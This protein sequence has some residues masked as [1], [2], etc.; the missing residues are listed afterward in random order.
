[1]Q[2]HF[3]VWIESPYLNDWGE[4]AKTDA[5][6][7]GDAELDSRTEPKHSVINP[8]G[9]HYGLP[10]EKPHSIRPEMPGS[11]YDP[12]MTRELQTVA[13][14]AGVGYEAVSSDGSRT[15]FAGSRGLLI[16]ERGYTR[17]N[18]AIFEE[19]LHT[20]VYE[21]FIEHEVSFGKPPLRMPG[22]DEDKQRY[23]RARYNR[24][25]QEWVDPLK[26]SKA[27]ESKI[28]SRLTTEMDEAEDM[29][30]DI[31]E[32]YQTIQYQQKLREQYGIKDERVTYEPREL[33]DDDMNGK[34]GGK[35]DE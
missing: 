31:E 8:A 27:R 14:G 5:A 2:N 30:R 13:T 17:M 15:N 7:A 9:F 21:W 22:Y 34:T 24:P 12:F 28:K 29:G 1:L 3:G 32:I 11:Q 10:G 16:V 19:Q 20:K 25:I 33:D 26:D 23:L 4:I 6:L 18:Q 35:E